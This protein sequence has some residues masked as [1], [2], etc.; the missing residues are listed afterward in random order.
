VETIMK[1][2]SWFLSLL[3][4]VI[5]LPIHSHA[6]ENRAAADVAASPMQVADASVSVHCPLTVGGSFEA[7]TTAMK[8]ELVL[9]PAQRGM[10]EG[11]LAVDL[12]TLQTG[13]ALRDD[14][15][16][17]KY[18]EVGKGAEYQM[19]TLE[20]IR[21]D[22]VDPSHPVGKAKFTGKLTLHG[23][24]RPVSGTA[25]IKRAGDGF[26]VQA[27][28]PVKV[29]DFQIP[30]PSYLGV[31]VRDEVTVAVNFVAGSKARS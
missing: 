17:D 12:M 13:I 22:G 11:E 14:H 31:G 8:G 2:A 10:V 21:L 24:E 9:D 16:R 19:A 7:K 28:F 18:L 26:R 25:E 3:A 6:R 1:A 5:L 20:D 4:L 23:Q 30:S 29:S 27:T 15:L